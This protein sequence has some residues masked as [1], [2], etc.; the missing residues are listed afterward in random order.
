MK[1]TASIPMKIDGESG[2]AKG[3]MEKVKEAVWFH[4][5]PELVDS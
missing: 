1:K 4:L 2:D 5:L 3:E